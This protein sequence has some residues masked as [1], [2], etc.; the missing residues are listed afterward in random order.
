MAKAVK[1]TQK[2]QPPVNG[3]K[4]S[5]DRQP[6]PEN[7]S[8][9]WEQWRKERHLTQSIIAHM[10]G[11]DGKP[12]KAFR[13]YIESL[14]KN[15]KAGNPKAIETIN[16][17]LEDIE[18]SKSELTINPVQIIQLPHNGRNQDNSTTAGVSD[19]STK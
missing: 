9:G 2:R 6:P 19:Q 12:K 4:F 10:V 13:E 3:V 16:K 18:V 17:G 8:K 7:K 1:T 11:I 14:V 15:A 5:K